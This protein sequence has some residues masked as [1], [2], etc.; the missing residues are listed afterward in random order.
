MELNKAASEHEI[1]LFYRSGVLTGTVSEMLRAA[2][3]SIADK[4]AYQKTTASRGLTLNAPLDH[5]RTVVPAQRRRWLQIGAHLQAA[6]PNA[7]HVC[8]LHALSPRERQVVAY[9][10]Q[11]DSNKLI[12]YQL[13]ISLG[14]VSN[15][16]SR[17]IA[18]MGLRTRRELIRLYNKLLSPNGA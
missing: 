12:A 13:G 16:L 17:A 3:S 8:A 2:G 11:G 14:S 1:Q 7:A 15:T 5:P 10:A 9:V 4:E 6:Y 18:K